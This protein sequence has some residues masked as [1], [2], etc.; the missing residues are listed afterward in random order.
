M[1]VASIGCAGN[2]GR[3]ERRTYRDLIKFSSDYHMRRRMARSLGLPMLMGQPKEY[4]NL[5]LVRL[6]R[7]KPMKLYVICTRYFYY[8]STITNYINYGKNCNLLLFVYWNLNLKYYIFQFFFFC[9]CYNIFQ[10]LLLS[11][12][13]GTLHNPIIKIK[14]WHYN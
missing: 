5:L 14:N 11:W 7:T 8:E 12:Y 9:F 10:Y 2:P 3:W 6:F 1:I 4:A 13:H